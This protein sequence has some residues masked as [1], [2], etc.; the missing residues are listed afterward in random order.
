MWYKKSLIGI[1]EA[2][3]FSENFALIAELTDIYKLNIYNLKRKNN[4]ILK[5]FYKNW[6]IYLKNI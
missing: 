1:F 5:A 2:F 6:T 4:N 3:H